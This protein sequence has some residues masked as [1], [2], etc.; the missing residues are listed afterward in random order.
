MIS[1]NAT[2]VTDAKLS[3]VDISTTVEN[4]DAR[5]K[6]LKVEFPVNIRND[7]ASYETQFGITKRPTHYNTSWDVAKFEVCHHKFADYSE[8][9]KGVSILNNCKYGFSTHG[10]LMRL[11]LLRSPKAPDAHADMGTHEIKYA[12]YPHRGALSSDTVKLAHEFNYC[13]KYKLPKDIGMNFDD[14]ISISGDENVILSNIKEAKM[15][16]LSSPTIH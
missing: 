4:W 7:F 3:K 9:S 5:N 16:V 11:S 2:A 1:L 13:F 12:I 14:I 8:Y 15:I 10:N 6:F